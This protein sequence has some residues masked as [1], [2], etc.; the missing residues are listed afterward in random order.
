M[1]AIFRHAMPA[2]LMLAVAG[3]LPP[4]GWAR[5]AA[6]RTLPVSENLESRDFPLLAMMRAALGW[7]EAL[8]ADEAL[9]AL[10]RERQA[11][12]DA[13]KGCAPRPACLV[14]AW[15][16]T[17]DDIAAVDRAL[18]RVLR[19]RAMAKALVT[20]RMRASGQFALHAG[21]DDA[22]LL[23]AAWADAAAAMNR[24]LAVYGKGEAPLYPKIDA[25][26][27]DVAQP[28]FAYAVEALG[29][30]T[31]SQDRAEDL[32]FE[33]PLR[34]AL[35]LLLMNERTDAAAFLP[36][37]AG[38]NV[39]TMSALPDIKWR[40]YPYAALLVFGHGPEDGQSRTGVLGHLRLR[41][42]ADQFARGQAPVIILSGGNVHPNRTPFNE[43]VEMKKELV[44][45]YGVPA[46]RILIEPHARHT[47]TN[48]RN[49]A[50]MM[51]AAGIPADRDSLILSDPATIAY[52]GGKQLAERNMTEL[53]YQP[54][55]VMPGPGPLAL[56][57]R[58]DP[59]SLH[60]DARDPLD[61]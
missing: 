12:V 15:A 16:W 42:A 13:A 54:G 50:R 60:V 30:V 34:Y 11:R 21:R 1:K 10:G 36:L 46:D 53:G 17:P 40:R 14:D 8:R 47:T 9:A 35:G 58:P 18:E 56:R 41:L 39:A 59:V 7:A 51:F 55:R 43:A 57:F 2:V 27:F 23:S 31:R 25:N 48:L 44:A 22:A 52:I 33:A 45:H 24:I 6:S 38:D 61:P 20:E 32:I 4:A 28:G 26:I 19:N 5:K 49:I 37:L 3:A 29:A